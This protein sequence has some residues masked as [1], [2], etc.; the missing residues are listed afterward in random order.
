MNRNEVVKEK[1][2]N[3]VYFFNQIPILIELNLQN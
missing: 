1:K 3:M 2:N